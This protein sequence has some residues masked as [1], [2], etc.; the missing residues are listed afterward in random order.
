MFTLDLFVPKSTI[1]QEAVRL[2]G[3]CSQHTHTALPIFIMLAENN[4][5]NIYTRKVQQHCVKTIVCPLVT[6][7][8]G[9][10]AHRG[11]FPLVRISG[12]ALR[13]HPHEPPWKG[14]LPKCHKIHNTELR[15][16][17]KVLQMTTVLI[18][19]WYTPRLLRGHWLTHA[20]Y[21]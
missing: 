19:L 20:C 8:T 16:P 14:L 13:L 18:Q 15:K 11:R 9:C 21:L 3:S 10:S 5:Y 6:M 4:P 7:A 17:I 2:K 12:T 1:V